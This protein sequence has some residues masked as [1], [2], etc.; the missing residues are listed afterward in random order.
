[1]NVRRPDVS[2]GGKQRQDQCRSCKEYGSIRQKITDE[3]YKTACEQPSCRSEALIASE[4][5]AKRRLANEAEANGSYRQPQEAAADRLE[6]QGCEHHRKSR[7]ERNGQRGRGD[8]KGAPDDSG[9]LGTDGVEQFTGRHLAHQSGRPSCRQD[10]TD[11]LLGPVLA[12]QVGGD[13]RAEALMLGA[14]LNRR[15]AAG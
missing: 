8:H 7:P 9:P 12:C 13:I 15:R 2:E 4:P 14:P 3:A 5:L 6:R 1:V 10:K 11:I